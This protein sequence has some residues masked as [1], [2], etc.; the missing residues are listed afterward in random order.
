[1]PSFRLQMMRISHRINRSVGI[2]WG[3]SFPF[4]YVSEYPKSGGTWLSQMIGDVLQLPVPQRSTMPIGC[5]S[6]LHNHWAYHKGLRR[7]AYLYR[8]GR[9][10]MVS[11]VFHVLREY[12]NPGARA[13]SI[14]RAR[15][16]RLFGSSF[17]AEDTATILPRLV[18]DLF[19]KPL[20]NRQ[21]WPEHI[22]DWYDP[23]SRPHI[24]YVSYEQLLEDPR[25][26]LRRVVEHIGDREVEPW[27]IEMTVEKFS[28]KRQTGRSAGLEDRSHF[29][30][31][32]VAGDW[33]NHF[34]PEAARVFDQHAGEEL[35]RLGYERDRSWIARLGE[36]ESAHPESARSSK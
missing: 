5:A 3:E 23:D 36:T 13:H 11:A 15:L 10:A 1:M 27:R 21:T 34:T 32:G 6:V 2:R 28:I 9:D 31:K 30:R 22:R 33:E 12:K 25:A 17:D 7:V 8:D 16:H 4:Y 26:H 29:I 24:A 14:A 19:S 20:G 18:E 35:V